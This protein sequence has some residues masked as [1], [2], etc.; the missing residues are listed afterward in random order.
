MEAAGGGLVSLRVVSVDSRQKRKWN[1]VK[2]V[3]QSLMCWFKPE[4]QFPERKAVWKV[5]L[6]NLLRGLP[7]ARAERRIIG[8]RGVVA[9]SLALV[10]ILLRSFSTL[11]F[12]NVFGSLVSDCPMALPIF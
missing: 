4:I 7:S 5:S 3:F 11:F 10:N 2:Q 9:S 8:N 6:T 1:G 12:G